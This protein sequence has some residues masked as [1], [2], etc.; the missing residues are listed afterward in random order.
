MTEDLFARA[1]SAMKIKETASQD[2]RR[3]EVLKVFSPLALGVVVKLSW[4]SVNVVLSSDT[5]MVPE[6]IVRM[7]RNSRYWLHSR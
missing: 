4:M 1:P 2:G 7:T 6:I 3:G 5:N